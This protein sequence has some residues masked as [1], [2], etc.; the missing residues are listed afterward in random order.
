MALTFGSLFAGIGGFDL[1]FERAGLTCKWQVEIDAYCNKILE[2]HWPD[3][4]RY[5]DV[6]DCGRHNLKPVDV[7]CGG[8][9]CQPIS[10]AG[11]RKGDK[12]A[13]W[14]WPNFYR[15]ICELK[16]K[17]VVVENVRGLLS[18]QRGQLFGEILRDLAQIG[19]NAEWEVLP[20]RCFGAPHLRARVFIIAY[21]SSAGLQ[22]CVFEK[23]LRSKQGASPT[24]FGNRNIACGDWWRTHLSDIYLGDGIS[25][26]LARRHLRVLGNAVVPQVTQFIGECIMEVNGQD[27]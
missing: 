20:A 9:P 14:L 10:V 19:Y 5:K 21:P 25:T 6:Q 2:K 24:K 17:W 23:S 4:M 16:P 13:R 18:A 8:F 26:K 3:V 15:I 1:G 12:D 11:R 7:I 27:E 22:R